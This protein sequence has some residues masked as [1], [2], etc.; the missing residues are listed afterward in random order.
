M[1]MVVQAWHAGER[2]RRITNKREAIELD[3]VS[4]GPARATQ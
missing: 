3:I 2:G 4:F 1:G